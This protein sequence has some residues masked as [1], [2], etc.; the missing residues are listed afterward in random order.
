MTGPQFGNE[1]LNDTQQLPIKF[2][3]LDI[4]RYTKRY[5]WIVLSALWRRDPVE[6]GPSYRRQK[7]QT[8]CPSQRNRYEPGDTLTKV[9]GKPKRIVEL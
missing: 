5:P 9:S 1:S 7:K 3:L 4:L 8:H 6:Q 2:G